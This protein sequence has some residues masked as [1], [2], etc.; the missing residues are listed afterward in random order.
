MPFQNPIYLTVEEIRDITRYNHYIPFVRGFHHE[1][2]TKRFP[3][4]SW[5]QLLPRL[6]GSKVVRTH[7]DCVACSRLA[8]GL[9]IDSDIEGVWVKQNPSGVRIKVV[10]KIGAE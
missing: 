7:N 6:V 4:W 1:F 8:M 2:I 9:C 3:G 10:K 5:N